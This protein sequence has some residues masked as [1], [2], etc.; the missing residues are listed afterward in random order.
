[1]ALPEVTHENVLQAGSA[2]ARLAKLYAEA[3]FVT[4]A[5]QDAAAVE[6]ATEELNAFVS[7]VLDKDPRAEA[8]LSSPAVGKKAKLAVLD[9]ALPGHVSDLLRGLLATL[10]RN[11][12]LDLVRGIAAAY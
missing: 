12:R 5:K 7:G 8:F 6:R 1:M 9:S 3:L 11:N 4:A 10:A 2:R